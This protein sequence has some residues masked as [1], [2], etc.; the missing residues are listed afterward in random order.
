VQQSVDTIG[1]LTSVADTKNSTTTTRASGYTYNPSEQVL[2]FSY[3]N[4]VAATFNYNSTR[5][6]LT[7]LSYAKGTQ[8]LFSLSYYYQNDPTNC[9]TGTTGNDGEIDCISDGVDSGRTAAYTYDSLGRVITA[10]TNGST[11]Y[12]K[13]GLSWAYDRYANRLNQTL[14]A[15]SGYTNLL[16]FSN[17]GGAQTNRPDGMCF[18]ASGNMLA[19]TNVSC[20]PAAPMYSYDA[21][22]RMTAY[23]G[24][25][26]AGYVYDDS[27]RRVKKCLPNCTSPTSSTVYVFSVG[28]D[29]AEY[30]NGAAPASPSR[31]YIYSGGSLLSTL[32]STATTYHHSDHLS[33][34]LSTDTNGNKVGEQGHYPYGEAWYSAN[35]TT[36]FVFTS[37]E[38]DS[39]SNNDYAMARYY[40]VG[41]GRFCSADPISGSPGDPQ[42]W[43]R[44]VYARDNP[45][46]ITDPSGLSWLGTFFKA[47]IDFFTLGFGNQVSVSP[48]PTFPN[49]S[50]GLS[51]WDK[52]VDAVF[53][54]M[55]PVIDESGGFG[56][57]F[58]ASQ[59]AG[60]LVL[61]KDQ[62]I[63][64][65][66]S[67]LLALLAN[68]G[69]CLK[70]LGRYGADVLK[71]LKN[72]PITHERLS[73]DMHTQAET[74]NAQPSVDSIGDQGISALVPQNPNIVINDRGFFF[75]RTDDTAF[76]G[77]TLLH[78]LGH[79]T[80][81][82]FDDYYPDDPAT[83]DK[84]QK[85]NDDL[86]KKNCAKTY[87]SLGGRR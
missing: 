83:T 59:N 28:R 19:E 47:L 38:R 23:Q 74:E 84:M 17:P 79:A 71:T 50:D 25:S 40:R 8:T 2:G 24:S 32:T 85:Q 10:V 18:D 56:Q 31:E 54:H 41:F 51:P 12:P 62:I 35:T 87:S 44:Y 20:P 73:G 34:R 1:R 75:T 69:D 11:A 66:R 22:S 53:P 58:A 48:Q 60:G 29:I 68:D 7:S 70:F 6:Q 49:P 36:K 39:E 80:G 26:S 13:W 61:S 16:T 5:Q 77:K 72:V 52:L 86:L 14:T 67:I 63:D 57:G 64:N 30:D 46:N 76:Q 3:G 37:Y 42:S 9:T 43:N 27:G 4:G 45:I 65:V 15:G 55:S 78:E 21:D 81:A 33:V 82:L